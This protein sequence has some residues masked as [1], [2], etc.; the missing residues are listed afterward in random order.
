MSYGSE[1]YGSVQFGGMPEE[2]DQE[3]PAPSGGS[4][5]KFLMMGV[6]AFVPFL[7]VLLGT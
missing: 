1:S 2:G 5:T 4:S 3:L 7:L 6:R